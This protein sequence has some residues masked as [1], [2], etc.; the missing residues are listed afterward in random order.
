M[1]ERIMRTKE[2]L[3][4]SDLKRA[5]MYRKRQPDPHFPKPIKL[6][7]RGVGLS[8]KEADDYIQMLM[9]TRGIYEIVM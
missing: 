4:K 2:F 7:D 5:S 9:E 1:S 8:E 3:H 6:G